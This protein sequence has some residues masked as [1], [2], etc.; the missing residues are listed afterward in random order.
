[1]VVPPGLSGKISY[2]FY[3]IFIWN[4]AFPCFPG[5]SRVKES[6]CQLRRCRR[7]GFDPWAGN[8]P[9]R[10]KWQPTLVLLLMNPMDRGAW[11]ATVHGVSKNQTWLSNWT[12][13]HFL[14]TNKDWRSLLLWT[15][16][17]RVFQDGNSLT[18]W[19]YFVL[20]AGS[21]SWWLST[22]KMHIG[23][24]VIFQRI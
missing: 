8:I 9:W 16:P 1:M 4:T 18:I 10:R 12:H 5:G 2:V 3:K 17:L 13:T 19:S 11:W 15:W 7:L 23:M 22:A 24:E 20:I 21:P 14:A 6:A